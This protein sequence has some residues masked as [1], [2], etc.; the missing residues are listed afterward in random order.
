M[1]LEL[2]I[3]DTFTYKT[4]K[5]QGKIEGEKNNRDKMILSLYK[6][7]KLSIH[8]IAI[9]ADV[10]EQYVLDLI[11]EAEKVETIPLKRAKKKK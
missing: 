9:S 5:K 7:T 3:E 8:E 6:N 1:A 2:K 4:G 10:S 11:K